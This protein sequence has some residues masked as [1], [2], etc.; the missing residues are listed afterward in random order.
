MAISMYMH[1]SNMCTNVYTLLRVSQVHLFFL[2]VEDMDSYLRR[3]FILVLLTPL[4]HLVSS[5]L[6]GSHCYIKESKSWIEADQYCR[7]HLSGLL[8][9]RDGHEPSHSGDGWVGLRRTDGVW[10]WAGGQP[11][12]VLRWEGGEQN[13]Q[14][15]ILT[16]VLHQRVVIWKYCIYYL[17][18]PNP[19]C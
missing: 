14:R 5:D 11:L 19:R 7:T 15:N 8:T 9:V 16:G 18:I 13:M 2:S 3:V 1:M 12:G 10:T 6:R 17:F 4:M